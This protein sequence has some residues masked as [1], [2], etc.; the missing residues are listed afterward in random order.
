MWN[1]C[2]Y[3]AVWTFS[4]IA[5][6]WD[7]NENRP[8]ESCGCCQVFQICWHMKCS[9]FTASS[10][11]SWNSPAGIPSPP[12]ALFI[13][14][15]PKVHL[16][17]N[18]RRSGSRWVTTQLWLSEILRTFLHSSFVYSCH[19]I[20][21]SSASVR[22]IP[23]LSFIV[24]IFAWNVPLLSLIFLKRTL[25]FPSL[26]FSSISFHW[27]LRN[28]FLSLIAILWNCA[29]RRV[30]ISFRLRFFSL[31]LILFT[32]WRFLKSSLWYNVH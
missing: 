19:L 18:S 30:Y 1:E 15:L 7:W 9:T 26:L 25:V 20:L 16:T 17:S 28:A 5:F 12:V 24:P 22:S 13:V 6:L 11:R 21:I 8:F 27:L 32:F 23:F 3:V 10:Y 2:N 14:M 31:C 4:G 29:F